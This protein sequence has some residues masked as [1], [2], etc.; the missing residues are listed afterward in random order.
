MVYPGETG[1]MLRRLASLE[2]EPLAGT[3]GAA[4]PV[5]SPDGGWLVFGQRGQLQRMSLRG[6]PPLPIENAIVRLPMG[7]SWGPDGT[8]VY[9]AGVAEGLWRIAP[10]GGAAERITTPEGQPGEH[11][12]RF[13]DVLPDGRTVLFAIETAGSFDEATIVALSLDSGEKKVLVEGGTRPTYL[14]SGHLAWVR[15][16][17]VLVA[18][19]DR[20]KLELTGPAVPLVEDVS[21]APAFGHAAVRFSA[22]GSLVYV[23]SRGSDQRVLVWVDHN[24]EEQPLSRYTRAFSSPRLSPD[25]RRLAV[26]VQ[27]Q[28]ERSDIWILDT[29]R[30]ALERLTSTGN[31]AFPIWSPDGDRVAFTS[32]RAGGRGNIFLKQVGSSL[33]AEQPLPTERW[34][35]PQSWSADGK[36]IVYTRTATD[37]R[38]EI[39][40]LSLEEEPESRLAVDSPFHERRARLSPDGRW[41]AFAGGNEVYVQEFPEGERRRQIS[42]NGGGEPLWA[43]DGRELYYRSSDGKVMAVRIQTEPELQ[44]STPVA[45]FDDRYEQDSFDISPDGARFVMMRRADDAP[46]PRLRV[47]VNWLP[48]LERLVPSSN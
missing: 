19:F 44:P 13:P 22:S 1:L 47:I 41:L 11:S 35:V 20:D 17:V 2:P 38:N 30:Q 24:G 27:V 26:A 42:T 15:S 10:G 3:N 40:S 28:G 39:W 45:L 7:T 43:P 29:S 5:F 8:I 46:P 18:P 36:R 25:G 6:G 37:N 21:Y 4:Y 31:N 33:E 48:E 14:P 12:H 34:Q 23:S 32:D 9:N 16:G